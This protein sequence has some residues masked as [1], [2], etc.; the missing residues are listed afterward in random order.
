MITEFRVPLPC[1]VEEFQRGQLY[2]VIK[3]SKE[4]TGGGEGVEWLK[5]EPY[6]NTDGHMGNSE[7]SGVEIPK[8]KGQYTLK[9]YHMASKIPG[10]VRAMLP[11]SAMF[12]YEE[13]FNAYPH[14]KTVLTN[15][16]L[17]PKKFKI[18]IESFHANDDGQTENIFNLPK[19]LLKKRKVEMLDIRN[20]PE[21]KEEYK[22]E[23]D[24]KKFHSELTGRGPLI[25]DD[26]KEKNS[27][28]M[29]CYKLMTI[30]F[31]Y[32]GLQKKIE[33]SSTA[34]NHNL[35]TQS[36][37]TAFCLIDE[38]FNLSL[39]DIRKLEAD[40]KSELEA[41]IKI[42]APKELVDDESVEKSADSTEKCT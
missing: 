36:L 20:D 6:D 19:D 21:K 1:D 7:I 12:L 10:V 31:K 11:K 25:E 28:I 26:W 4:N 32:W 42:G 13:A 8:T 39:D 34:F 2:M 38:W 9:K 22:E 35:F 3:M 14:C 33:K 16:F 23:Y 15:G 40:L 18:V 37:G 27:P 41:Q 17:A 30:D 24:C 5:N 29:C